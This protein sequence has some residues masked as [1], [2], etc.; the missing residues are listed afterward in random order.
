[1]NIIHPDDLYAIDF[2]RPDAK[3]GPWIAGGAALRWFQGRPVGSSDIDVFCRNAEQAIKI[4]NRLTKTHHRIKCQTDNAITIEIYNSG[5][6]FTDRKSWIIQ[7]ITRKFYENMQEIIDSFDISVCEIVTAGD[8][9]ILGKF[10]ARD[11]R[12]KNLRFTNIQSDAPKRLAKYWTYGY[13]PIEGTLEK[14]LNN[15]KM[16]WE[17]DPDHDYHHAFEDFTVETT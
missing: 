3:K 2:I 6:V 16:R 12:E 11:I 15:E 13:R 17:Y 5:D 4:Q 1:M 8:E 10:T 9:W 14:I 7:I